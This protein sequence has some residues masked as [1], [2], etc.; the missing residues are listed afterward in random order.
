M[1]E[2]YRHVLQDGQAEAYRKA[3]LHFLN[4]DED[5]HNWAAF[6]LIGPGRPFPTPAKIDPEITTFK[7]G[8]DRFPL[9][10]GTIANFGGRNLNK[11]V[12]PRLAYRNSDFVV[13]W[14]SIVG[15]NELGDCLVPSLAPLAVLFQ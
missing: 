11:L 8:F 9:F 13:R 2:F 12:G 10:G 4:A 3:C 5:L 7:N 6:V 1:E 14:L 15:L